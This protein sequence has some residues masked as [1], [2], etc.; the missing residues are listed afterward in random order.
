M[1][2]SRYEAIYNFPENFEWN[3]VESIK[4][5]EIGERLSQAI[6]K[7]LQTKD[8]IFVPGLRLTLRILLENYKLI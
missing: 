8:R 1:K 2:D 3:L 6:K 7:D 4:I 5:S